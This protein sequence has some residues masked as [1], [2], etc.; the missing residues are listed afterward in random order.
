M[1]LDRSLIKSNLFEAREKA[2]FFPSIHPTQNT[3]S[4]RRR[5]SILDRL[6]V[7]LISLHHDRS[8]EEATCEI[9]RKDTLPHDRA[10][11]SLSARQVACALLS[12]EEAR[13]AVSRSLRV[14]TSRAVRLSRSGGDDTKPVSA[15]AV[16]WKT[17][18]VCRRRRRT[19]K[20]DDLACVFV[21]TRWKFWRSRA[22][23]ALFR[24]A[25]CSA[26]IS[27]S[28]PSHS[29]VGDFFL[30]RSS[31]KVLIRWTPSR[32]ERAPPIRARTPL[33]K[34]SRA[35]T[36]LIIQTLTNSFFLAILESLG[37]EIWIGRYLG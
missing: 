20:R 31:P 34:H 16:S 9:C 12:G 10:S 19:R 11:E 33:E 37:Y 15:S 35:I 24:D 13:R 14:S 21:E 32:D 28:V 36:R 3:Y 22:R 26:P 18:G 30:G 6:L 25:G 8:L 7:L 2:R 27:L 1:R 5:V 23:A 29:Y 17:L 4:P